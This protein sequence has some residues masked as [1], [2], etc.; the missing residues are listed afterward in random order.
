LLE[1]PT[2]PIEGSAVGEKL[3]LTR[4]GALYAMRGLY[5]QGLLKFGD[6][7]D[8][9]WWKMR[10]GDPTPPLTRDQ[11]LVLSATP[12][13][14]GVNVK[15]IHRRTRLGGDTI[16]AASRAL[17]NAGLVE[18]AGEFIG[19]ALF[20]ATT[21]GVGHPRTPPNIRDAEP[22]AFPVDSDRIRSF[23]STGKRL[24]DP[25]ALTPMGRDA[26]AS[27]KQRRAAWAGRHA[28]P[29]S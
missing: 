6:P 5:G 17:V 8:P 20:R 21:A 14:Y 23:L 22:P 4:Q 7:D 26:L 15:K 28:F 3:G 11:E 18:A 9:S 1:L 29:G 27:M 16:E 10:A 19:G 24:G 13:D 2:E 12:S 25:Y